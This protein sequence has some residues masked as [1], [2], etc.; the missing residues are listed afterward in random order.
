MYQSAQKQVASM[1]WYAD[2]WAYHNSFLEYQTKKCPYKK[3]YYN[4]DK[5]K[6]KMFHSGWMKT[7]KLY[8]LQPGDNL[9]NV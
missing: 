2:C 9:C 3:D 6:L 5:S 1:W 7:E 8:E 4:R